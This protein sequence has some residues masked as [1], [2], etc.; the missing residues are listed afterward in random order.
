MVR[1]ALL[2][3]A[4]AA[5]IGPSA[6]A[7]QC[8]RIGEQVCRSGSL[9]TCESCGAVNCLVF[10]GRSCGYEVPAAS[11]AGTWSGS[12]HQ[13]GGGA[14]RQNYPVV[15]TINSGGG[16]IDY[17]SLKCGGSLMEL[18]N[19]GTSAEYRE[20]ITYGNCIDGGTIS[21]S[22]ADGKLHWVWTGSGIGVTAML[23]R[24]TE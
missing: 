17:P 12:G 21:V 11:L 13:T 3:L 7:A 9:Y 10:S 23:E 20:R 8:A 1:G 14:P 4:V 6:A 2:T 24:R 19:S 5:L 18:S 16:T 22:F 15:M